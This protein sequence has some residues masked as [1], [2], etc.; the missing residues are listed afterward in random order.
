MYRLPVKSLLRFAHRTEPKVEDLPHFP[1]A[2]SNTVC[3]QP[4]HLSLKQLQSKALSHEEQSCASRNKVVQEP[5]KRDGT[6]T[7][8]PKW[9]VLLLDH[10]NYLPS[11]FFSIHGSFLGLRH[12]L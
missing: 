12:S 10:A 11:V 1:I 2:I 8:E 7:P 4:V 5:G 9:L 3:V 6:T